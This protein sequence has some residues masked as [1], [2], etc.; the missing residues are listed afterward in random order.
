MKPA[1]AGKHWRKTVMRILIGYCGVEKI[2]DSPGNEV[3]CGR[4]D[5]KSA[6]LLDLSPDHKVSRVHGRIWQ[7][8]GVY[9][10]EDLNSRRGTRLNGLEIKRGEKQQFRPGVLI[11]VG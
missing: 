9:W 5:E 8:G 6:T 7:E 3:V 2:W 10:I 1:V 11:V 4:T